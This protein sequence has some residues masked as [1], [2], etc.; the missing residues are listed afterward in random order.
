ML[1]TN[2]DQTVLLGAEALTVTAALPTGPS[3]VLRDINFRLFKGRTLGLVGE[4]GAG[5]SMLGRVIARQLP[6]GFGVSAGQLN[7]GG[8]DLLQLPAAQHARLLGDRIAFIPQ[9]PMTALNPVHRIGDQFTEHLLRLG[10]PSAQ[11][12]ERVLE[13]LAEVRLPDPVAVFDKYAFQLSGGM[14]Q[15][16]MIAMAFAS[17]PDLVI[18]D[19]ATTALDVRTQAHVVDLLRRLQQDRGTGV[20]FVTHDMGL[21]TH[22]CDDVAVLYAGDVV[23]SGPAR[24]VFQ[25]G[26]HPYTRALQG[27]IPEL[28]GP[29]RRL[30]SLPGQMPGVS[31]FP[32][33]GGCRFQPRCAQ[34]ELA[35][36]Q[37]PPVLSEAAE[38]HHVRCIRPVPYDA[39]EGERVEAAPPPGAAMSE[40]A[41]LEV[42]GLGKDY[43]SGRAW[44]RS[45]APVTALHEV[46]L[47]IAPGEFV[48]VVG[49]SGSGKSTLARLVMGLEQPSRGSIVLNGRVLGG[50]RREWERRIASIQ[51]IFQDARSALNPRRRVGTLLTQ[52]ME[53]RPHLQSDRQARALS[54]AADVGLAADA[55][56]RFP[57][58]MSGGQRQRINIGRALCDLPQLLVADEIVSGLDVSVQA[59]IL[60]LLLQLRQEHKVS[61]LLISHDLGVVRH[62][63]SRVLVMHQGRVVEQGATET[64][65]GQPQH[66]YT[67]SLI[68][69]V[70]PTDPDA[71]WPPAVAPVHPLLQSA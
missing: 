70:P 29:L 53:A 40:S 50:D 8:Q 9:E 58:Q 34:A 64:V 3:A 17:H 22:A 18:S 26:V 38:G 36:G 20:L 25:H 49:E 23:E 65:L 5:K 48:G 43:V 31:T 32:T 11:C 63:C 44:W 66:P 42:K 59:Q 55:V 6:S 10:V 57:S 1:E 14:C 33:L 67:R 56:D 7:F 46:D 16:V 19:E 60:N 13:A 52:A 30:S 28:M 39:G 69:A 45:A 62:L 4:S 51:M 12:R 24:R 41:C 68:A 47:R 21:A 35:C 15:R 71:V 61:L 54:L 2:T 27:A 37:A